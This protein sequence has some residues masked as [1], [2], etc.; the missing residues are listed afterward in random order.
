MRCGPTFPVLLA[1]HAHIFNDLVSRP[2]AFCHFASSKHSVCR[3]L[4]RQKSL[5]TTFFHLFQ[6]SWLNNSVPNFHFHFPF[7]IFFF[8]NVCGTFYEMAVALNALVHFKRYQ[9]IVNDVKRAILFRL[10]NKK[11]ENK[12]RSDFYWSSFDRF[13]DVLQNLVEHLKSMDVP[14]FPITWTQIKVLIQKIELI[15]FIRWIS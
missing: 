2:F 15:N 3:Q 6:K 12:I 9:H 10:Q 11:Q 7:A 14:H 1:M 13:M 5:R 4:W 8:T